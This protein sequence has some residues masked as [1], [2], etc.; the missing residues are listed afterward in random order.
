M[1]EHNAFI[2]IGPFSVV[3]RYTRTGI[4]LKPYPQFPQQLTTE[5]KAGIGQYQVG[6]E[7]ERFI[8]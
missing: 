3:P 8:T 7:K 1:N 6:W 5:T 4:G 2:Q